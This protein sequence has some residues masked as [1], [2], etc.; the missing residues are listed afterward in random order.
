VWLETLSLPGEVKRKRRGERGE[1]AVHILPKK[2][3]IAFFR[4]RV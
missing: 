3:E 2:I 4:I 1:R